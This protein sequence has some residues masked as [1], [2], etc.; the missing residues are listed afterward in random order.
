M[1]D[2]RQVTGR[3]FSVSDAP[4]EIPVVK[5]LSAIVVRSMARL[6]GGGLSMFAARI[7]S[8]LNCS[9]RQKREAYTFLRLS[10]KI[11]AASI[12]FTAGRGR[13]GTIS[14]RRS[15]ASTFMK[16]C[17]IDILGCAGGMRITWER[18]KVIRLPSFLFSI[19]SADR[20]SSGLQRCTYHL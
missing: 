1:E 10:R 17:S 13:G 16:R 7:L 4:D 20:D 9:R 11:S 5:L 18:T 2:Q 19:K 6:P 3:H 12:G 8:S 14:A 15:V